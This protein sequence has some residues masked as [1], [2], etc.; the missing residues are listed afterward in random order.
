[1]SLQTVLLPFNRKKS[2]KLYLYYLNL[3]DLTFVGDNNN[4]SINETF[5]KDTTFPSIV[6]ISFSWGSILN[7]NESISSG[8]IS[9]NTNGVEI[10]KMGIV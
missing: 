8:N 6:N 10:S 1:M 7:N 2:T 4:A 5:I 3:P 9:I